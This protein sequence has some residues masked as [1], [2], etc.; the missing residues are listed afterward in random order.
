[1][2]R[3]TL[4]VLT[5][6]LAGCDQQSAPPEQIYP[7]QITLLPDGGSR[8]FGITL[9]DTQLGQAQS[10]LGAHFDAGLFENPDGSLSLEIFYNEVTL[11][12]LSGKFILTLAASQD[13]LEAMRERAVGQK[14]TDSGALRYRLAKTEQQNMLKL[15]ISAISYIP[16]VDLDEEMV[17]QRFGTPLDRIVVAEGKRHLLYPDKGLDLLLDNDGKELLQYVAPRD[18]SR[19]LQP[20]LRPSDS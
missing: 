3:I 7:W 12:G 4:L 1:M 17:Q 11:G 16:Y 9:N 6:L 10:V 8:V 15:P 19:L 18:F 13:L 2:Y 14:R 5:L 20:L